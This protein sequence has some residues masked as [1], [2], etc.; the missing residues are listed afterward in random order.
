MV[1][2]TFLRGLMKLC[3]EILVDTNVLVSAFNTKDSLH[4]KAVRIMDECPKPF[5]L[6]EYVV[7]ETTTVLMNR[8]SK[9][10]ADAFLKSTFDSAD[11]WIL[12]SNQSA[13]L[14]VSE[15]FLKHKLSFADAA[16]LALSDE[17]NVL[18]FDKALQKAIQAKKS[19]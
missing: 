19:K 3:M 17:Y 18:T 14:D 11:S 10:V 5:V 15:A 6:H 8:A 7:L 12:Y 2:Q 16:L 4:E 1:T 13:F 9:A